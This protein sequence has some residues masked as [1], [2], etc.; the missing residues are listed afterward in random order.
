MADESTQIAVDHYTADE[1]VAES[2]ASEV[3]S[4]RSSINDYIYENGRRY[5][6]YHAGSYWGSNDEKAMDALDISHHVYMLLLRG[7]LH[8]APIPNEVNRVLD[9]G[10]GT[11][12]WAMDFADLH[13]EAS[14]IGTDLSPIQP[15]FVPS[16]LRFEVD[17]CC[18]D[19]LYEKP[20]DFIHARGLFGCVSD[21]DRFYKQALQH[22]VP[23]GYL[24]QVEWSVW[25]D[26]DDGSAKGTKMD[27][28]GHISLEA[29]KKFGKSLQT[30]NEMEEN[31]KKA[32]FT[33]VTVHT[34]KIP[35]GP[36]PQDKRLKNLG[37]YQRLVWEESLEMWVMM[38]W[39]S[40]L[41][42]RR[43]EVE[44]HLMEVR[45]ELRNS[46][47]HAYQ[48]AYVFLLPYSKSFI[49]SIPGG[50]AMDENQPSRQYRYESTI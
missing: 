49:D 26:S 40:I 23:G 37:R 17:D 14:V 45:N 10:T 16:N 36:W 32:G 12:V 27:E 44:L 5:H 21:W 35:V 15:A 19:W 13:P 31:M 22:L 38:L 6:A 42:W 41:G 28:S 25:V 2:T 33:D 34:F 18:D 7:K 29:A 8:L 30:V 46:K 1:W 48:I 9:V 11:G 3:T 39:T 47:I 20:F 50:F 24:E 4:L 43:E